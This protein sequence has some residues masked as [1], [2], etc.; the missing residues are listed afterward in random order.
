MFN[1]LLIEVWHVW[2]LK[3]QHFLKCAS[4]VV[5]CEE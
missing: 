4:V 2:A 3:S 5:E 1:Q